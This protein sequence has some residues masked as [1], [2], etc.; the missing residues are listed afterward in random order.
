MTGPTG[1]TFLSNHARVLI[2]I[3][4]DPRIR[5]G[6]LADRV[7]I[8]RRAVQRIIGELEDAG[9]LSRVREGRRNRYGVH[10]DLPLRHPLGAQCRVGGMLDLFLKPKR[11][12][13]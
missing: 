9:Y 10:K 11:P 6:D 2:C 12:P 4:Q 8:T 3:A 13:G 1:W 7:H 5:L